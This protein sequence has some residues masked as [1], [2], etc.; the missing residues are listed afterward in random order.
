LRRAD[1]VIVLSLVFRFLWGKDLRKIPLV[2]FKL[3]LI[4]ARRIFGRGHAQC[5]P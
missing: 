4:M 3:L 1:S 5:I 2:F